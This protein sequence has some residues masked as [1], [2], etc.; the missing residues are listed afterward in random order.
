MYVLKFSKTKAVVFI[1]N[2]SSSFLLV[3]SF[4][5]SNSNLEILNFGVFSHSK[6]YEILIS[7]KV[8]GSFKHIIKKVALKLF[9]KYATFFFT[10][11]G[12]ILVSKKQ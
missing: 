2:N 1:S 10:Y 3:S 4:A 6:N 12:G 8:A 7:G 9:P 11:T 5:M